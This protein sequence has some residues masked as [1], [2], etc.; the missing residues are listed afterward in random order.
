MKSNML[1]LKREQMIMGTCGNK[2]IRILD[3]DSV[4]TT[5]DQTIQ[6]K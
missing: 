6:V 3:F 2:S 5:Y 1:N 4:T